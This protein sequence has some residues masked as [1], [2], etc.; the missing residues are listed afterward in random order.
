M[1][2][3]LEVGGKIQHATYE[4][5]FSIGYKFWNNRQAIHVFELLNR[6]H[7][8]C[9]NEMNVFEHGPSVLVISPAEH[10]RAHCSRE[11]EEQG[12]LVSTSAEDRL[13]IQQ[14]RSHCF[15]LCIVET[16]L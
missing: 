2:V 9:S 14:I 4:K 3:S 11:L 13:V 6:T 12:N 8:Q 15:P 5:L 1:L 10:Q 16:H 7:D